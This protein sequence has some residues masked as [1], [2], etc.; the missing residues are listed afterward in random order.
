VS[1]FLACTTSEDALPVL[2][3]LFNQN[4]LNSTEIPMPHL[5]GMGISV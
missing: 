3:P 5:C 4:N 1:W 2:L